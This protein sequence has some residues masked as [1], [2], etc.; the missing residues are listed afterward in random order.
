MK[1]G[2]PIMVNPNSYVTTDK[3]L[4]VLKV[5]LSIG[6]KRE[7]GIVGCDGPP[8]C[9]ASRKIDQD[10]TLDW[11]AMVPGLGH[12]HMN[13]LKTFFK[14]FDQIFLEPLGKDV[15][16]FK[17]PNAYKFFVGAKDTHKAFQSLEIF[18]HG[19]VCELIKSYK[20]ADPSHSYDPDSFFEWIRTV[21]NE[22][23][24]LLQHSTWP[25]QSMR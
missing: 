5:E 3:C 9:L 10:D 25:L 2:E 13:Q 16:N 22:T 18:L 11:V 17:S 12:L 19:T 4:S 15:L 1:V 20:D 6:E 8:Y 23:F 14:V 21:E 24:Y 7:H